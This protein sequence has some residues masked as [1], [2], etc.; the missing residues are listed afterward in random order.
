VQAQQQQQ[1]MEGPCRNVITND[2][3]NPSHMP[4]SGSAEAAMHLFPPQATSEASHAGS[5]EATDLPAGESITVDVQPETADGGE[6]SR[7]LETALASMCLADLKNI[8]DIPTVDADTAAVDAPS[9]EGSETS[10]CELR[11]VLTLAV[12]QRESAVHEMR[13]AAERSTAAAAEAEALR[14]ERDAALEQI[15]EMRRELSQ[16]ELRQQ[17]REREHHE[18]LLVLHARVAEVQEL[19]SSAASALLE[20]CSLRRTLNNLRMKEARPGVGLPASSRITRGVA[21]VLARSGKF[22]G[23][24]PGVS[25]SVG[26]GGGP[27]WLKGAAPQ[28]SRL[29][30]HNNAHCAYNCL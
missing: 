7:T 22:I 2:L 26:G 3:F 30:S 25:G 11:D 18:K 24:V 15:I 16:C 10:H 29:G 21:G 14:A 28:S 19:R 23:I 9:Q 20:A 6:V 5:L 12:Q 8:H 4:V 17:E 27:R 13:A 1:V